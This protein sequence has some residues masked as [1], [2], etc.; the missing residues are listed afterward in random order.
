[1]TAIAAIRPTL[2]AVVNGSTTP[3]VTSSLS[4]GSGSRQ[5]LDELLV[6]GE[7]DDERGDERERG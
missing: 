3:S 4:S 7:R 6:V 2:T 1:M 5:P